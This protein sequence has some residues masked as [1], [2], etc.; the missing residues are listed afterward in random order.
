MPQLITIKLFTGFEQELINLFVSFTSSSRMI[1]YTE[2]DVKKTKYTSYMF[3]AS[4]D[5]VWKGFGSH[6]NIDRTS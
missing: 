5:K 3:L 6:R 1:I 2:V 4:T